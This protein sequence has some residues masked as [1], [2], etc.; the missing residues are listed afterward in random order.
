MEVADAEVCLRKSGALWLEA[1]GVLAAG[2]LHLEKGSSYASR[3]QLLPP[4]DTAATLDRLEAEVAALNPRVVALLGDSFH[5]GRATARLAARDAA[6]IV[7]LARSRTLVW[8]VGNHDREG[9]GALP[10]DR[11]DEITVAGLTL[12]HEPALVPVRGEVAGH[13]HPCARVAGHG[14]S[15]RRRCFLTDGQRLILPAFGS[16][17]GGLNARDQAFA[18]LFAR[19]PIAG[20][21]GRR[22]HAIGWG[23]LTGD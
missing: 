20:V 17:A 9:P 22:V 15:V 23:S 11:A 12:R 18:G 19:S 2:D 4:Y 13:L 8:I 10:G 6:R 16:Y 5:D 7:A 1:D 3:G 21:L 14:G